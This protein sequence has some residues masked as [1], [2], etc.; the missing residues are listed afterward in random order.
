MIA[1]FRC[2]LLSA[3]QLAALASGPL[4]RG[5]VATE[6]R[7]SQH[8]DLYLDT[9]DDSLRRRGIVCRLRT[10]V[11]GDGTLMLLL[12]SA[13]P[14][15]PPDRVEV[16]TGGADVSAVLVGNNA[17][18][19]RLR[20]L[21]DPSTLGVR[22]DL[23]VDR[24]TRWALRDWLWRPRLTLHLDR[25]VVRRTGVAGGASGGS[26][27]QMCA[28]QVRGGDAH[29][30]TLRR[31]LEEEHGIRASSIG[32]RDRAELAMKWAKLDDAPRLRRLTYSDRINRAVGGQ[33]PAAAPEF[34]NPELSLLS[35][36]ERVLA[37]AEDPSTPLRE[38][39]RFVSIVAANLDEFFMVR[40]AGLLAMAGEVSEE[41]PDGGLSVAEQVAAIRDSV[42]ELSSRQ[43]ACMRDCLR[44]LE[45]RNV[46]LRRWAEL[47]SEQQEALATRFR[48]EVQPLLTPFAMTLAPGHPLPRLAHLSLAIAAIVRNRA[49]GPPRFAELELP[50]SV[51]RF[52]EVASDDAAVFVTLEEMVYANLG[53]LYP[54]S[55]LE[56]AFV[57]RVT[58]S[59]ELALDEQGT[60]DLLDVVARATSGRGFGAAVRLEVERSMP[61]ILRALLLEDLRREQPSADVPFVTDV[62]EVDGL[63]DLA[64]LAELDL[65]HEKAISFPRFSPAK[66]FADVESVFGAIAERDALVHHPF[67]SFNATVSRFVREAAAD[68]AVLAIKITLY[69]IGDPSPIA[70]ALL[71]AARNGK[72][73]TVFVEVKARFDETLNVQWARALEAAGGHVVRGLVGFK[74]HAKVAL[75]VRREGDALRRYVHVGTG[76]YNARSGEQYTD[77]SLF[78]ADESIA[79]DVADLFNDLTGTSEAPRRVFR[80]LL[81][82]PEHLLSGIVEAIDREAA[83]ARAGRSARITIKCNGPSDPDVIRALY[84]ASRDGVEID[85]VIRGICT[86]VPGVTERSA[87]IRVVSV[88]GRFLEHSRIYRFANGGDARYYIGSADLRPRNLRRRVELLVPVKDAG[89]RRELDRVLDLYVNDPTGWLLAADGEYVQRNREGDSAQAV[90]IDNEAAYHR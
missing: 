33:L 43:A 63:L 44:E 57:F 62:E 4:P 79:S 75:V 45:Q 27:F 2:E 81:V 38:R 25:V 36:Q 73:V 70:D 89:Q 83:H 56:Q 86:L 47:T 88:V 15:S 10:R 34:L 16:P 76:N 48:D 1:G 5:V 30:E 82:A 69:R 7:R 90:L 53:A 9:T 32:V 14:A 77:L 46:H 65:P 54:D 11:D 18:V 20:G 3:D 78:T 59:A 35:F 55:T 39:L 87:R 84:R 41:Q 17:A 67:E 8:R 23:E 12:P 66:P 24:L 28:H 74:N 50:R 80:S 6:A 61:P 40:M 19:R 85:L 13:D 29:L 68:P 26:F 31:A 21:V 64:A 52:F 49:G 42:R 22:V 71:D 58:R 60:D 72:S 37:V 51:P